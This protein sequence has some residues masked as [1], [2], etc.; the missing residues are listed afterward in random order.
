MKNSR[1]KQ[2]VELLKLYTAVDNI[3]GEIIREALKNKGIPSVKQ[4]LGPGGV[5]N[6]YTGNSRWGEE[7]YVA[8]ENLE[9]AREILENI[10]LED[11]GEKQG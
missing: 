1:K 7:I 10:G 9:H 2:D 5:M 8:A 11:R 6:L 4:D 3:Q